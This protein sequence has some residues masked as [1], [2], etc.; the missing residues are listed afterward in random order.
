M[1]NLNVVNYI[2]RIINLFTCFKLKLVIINFFAF[3]LLSQLY[4]EETIKKKREQK[5]RIAID[6]IQYL[7]NP[8]TTA[9][10]FR[11][12]SKKL[13]PDKNLDDK[14]FAV[15]LFGIVSNL[16]EQCSNNSCKKE[17]FDQGLLKLRHEYM[18]NSNTE[19]PPHQELHYPSYTGTYN[20]Q[21]TNSAPTAEN[22]DDSIK[23]FRSSLLAIDSLVIRNNFVSEIMHRNNSTIEGRF[24]YAF[25]ILKFSDINPIAQFYNVIPIISYNKKGKIQNINSYYQAS[26]SAMLLRSL[27]SLDSNEYMDQYNELTLQNIF[28]FY[29]YRY[30]SRQHVGVVQANI[31]FK[32]TISL[33]FQPKIIYSIVSKKLFYSEFLSSLEIE[34]L[35][36]ASVLLGYNIRQSNND[37]Y[38]K[39]GL[40]LYNHYSSLLLYAQSYN[41]DDFNNPKFLQEIQKKSSASENNTQEK[42]ENSVF[43]SLIGIEAKL[44]LDDINLLAFGTIGSE[45]DLVHLNSS[46]STILNSFGYNLGC[47]IELADKDSAFF[48]VSL[49]IRSDS[50]LATQNI[51]EDINNYQFSD[52]TNYLNSTF[53]SFNLNLNL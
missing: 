20:Q 4:A 53:V 18:Q 51:T 39:L 13:H 8:A 45:S 25:A 24:D 22:I 43:S 32:K 11:N 7:I 50:S 41:F 37:N 38:T 19:A 16:Y 14:E 30:I 29:F 33:S 10:T 31:T 40:R 49:G 23:R 12:V 3:I 48:S 15:D 35:P 42:E 27:V 36:F 17:E 26:I 34:L 6:S 5:I 21:E 52:S 9:T 1:L 44:H 2:G 47:T 28:H 46:G